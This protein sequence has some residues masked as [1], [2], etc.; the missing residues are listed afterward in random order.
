MDLVNPPIWEY[1]WIWNLDIMPK[2][3][4]FLSQIC[5]ASLP[6]RG[7][8]AQRGMNIDSHCPFCESEIDNTN[9]L[10]LGCNVSQDCWGLA[11]SHNW[12]NTNLPF[13]P[14]LS[15]LQMLNGARAADSIVKMDRLVALLWS[16]WKARITW[17]FIMKNPIQ[18]QH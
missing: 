5:H 2:L 7:T 3:K 16:I 18:E 17:C 10:F 12:L 15:L 4:I 14:Q 6:T 11:V 1:N 9:H 8:L 13:N